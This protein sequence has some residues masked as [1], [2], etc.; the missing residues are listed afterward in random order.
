MSPLVEIVVT[1]ILAIY[2]M[3]RMWKKEDSK[4]LPGLRYLG[5]PADGSKDPR[6]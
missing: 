6:D 4:G 5:R 1:S 3:W 2:A